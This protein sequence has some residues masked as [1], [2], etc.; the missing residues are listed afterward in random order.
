[1][2]VSSPN[3]ARGHA[4]IYKFSCPLRQATLASDH[5]TTVM[6][7]GPS[8]SKI[9]FHILGPPTFTPKQITYSE[10]LTSEFTSRETQTQTNTNI[11][12][13]IP[14][15]HLVT[16]LFQIPDFG[17]PCLP[18]QLE[19]YL[20]VQLGFVWLHCSG[21]GFHCSEQLRS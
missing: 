19:F 1:M 14:V 10:I 12:V 17:D 6:Q 9:L 11:S 2:N 21:S 8:H 5:G 3:T 20:S 18:P 4:A 16:T 13:C 15:D 7:P